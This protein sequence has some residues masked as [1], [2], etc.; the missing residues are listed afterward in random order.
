MG[1]QVKGRE[2]EREKAWEGRRKVMAWEGKGDE[3]LT[4]NLKKEVEVL[5][6]LVGARQGGRGKGGDVGRK[7]GMKAAGRDNGRQEERSLRTIGKRWY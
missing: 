3:S 5:G 6:T 2:D 7:E 4:G 1:G